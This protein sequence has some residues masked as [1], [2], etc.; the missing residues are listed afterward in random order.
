MRKLAVVHHRFQEWASALREAEPRL[1]VRGW[2]PRDVPADP[3]LAD[4]E[5]LFVWK[6]PAGLVQRRTAATCLCA[7]VAAGCWSSEEMLRFEPGST[8]ASFQSVTS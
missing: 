7:R 1:E 4:A 8:Q 6:I 3:W 2:H 5:G